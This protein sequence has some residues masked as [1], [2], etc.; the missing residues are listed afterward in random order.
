MHDHRLTAEQPQ[1]A[2]SHAPLLSLSSFLSLSFPSSSS[3]VLPL[4]RSFRPRQRAV[5]ALCAGPNLDGDAGITAADFS[6]SPIPTKTF[7]EKRDCRGNE[8]IYIREISCYWRDITLRKKRFALGKHYINK[9]FI[10]KLLKLPKIHLKLNEGP[11]PVLCFRYLTFH[12]INGS[13][14]HVLAVFGSPFRLTLTD[15]ATLGGC[16]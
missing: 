3:L 4:F 6:L 9:Y 15:K 12:R 16:C 1:T 11:D 7:I 10:F 8:I 5:A 2:A 13:S 14:L